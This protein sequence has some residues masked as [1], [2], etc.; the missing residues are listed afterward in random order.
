[1]KEIYVV[2]ALIENDGKIMIAQRNKGDFEGLWEFPGG[3]VEEGETEQEALIREIHEEFDISINIKE[4]LTTIEHDYPNFHLKMSCYICTLQDG[5]I[6]LH[7]HYAIEW[8]DPEEQKIQWVPADI[9]A[10]S[11]YIE[12]KIR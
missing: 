4:Y 7:D 9:K 2:A 6:N 3:K 1:M 5:K 8:I 11:K 10:L 12:R